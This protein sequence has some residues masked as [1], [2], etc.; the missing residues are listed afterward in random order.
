MSQP[1]NAANDN[2]NT[3]TEMPQELRDFLRV[4]SEANI[5]REEAGVIFSQPFSTPTSKRFAQ[6][7]N[8]LSLVA[9]LSLKAD[10]ERSDDD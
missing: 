7:D 8:A 6:G 10:D 9:S 4:L 2:T 3:N 5:N 1:Q